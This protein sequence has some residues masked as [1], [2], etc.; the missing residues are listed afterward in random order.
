MSKKE[1]VSWQ[2]LIYSAL[3]Y[4]LSVYAYSFDIFKDEFIRE[5]LLLFITY[6][7][8]VVLF[9]MLFGGL[10]LSKK[11]N[12]DSKL[13][14][15]DKGILIPFIITTILIMGSVIFKI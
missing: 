6:A 5:A 12:T 8:I 15:E 4:I 3:I 13:I 14:L 7:R 1:K 11:Y 2:I 10:Y 9:A